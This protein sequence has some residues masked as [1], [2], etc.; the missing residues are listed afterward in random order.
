MNLSTPVTLS[1]AHTLTLS[2]THTNTLD[3][4]SQMN[5]W[6]NNIA[7]VR[8]K[9]LVCAFRLWSLLSA[10]P[11]ALCSNAKAQWDT[12]C[13]YRELITVQGVYPVGYEHA[14][15]RT[16]IHTNYLLHT[17]TNTQHFC[18][19][20][21]GGPSLY[22]PVCRHSSVTSLTAQNSMITP[23]PEERI[24]ISCAIS[25]ALFTVHKVCAAVVFLLK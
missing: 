16:H 18:Y 17:N 24:Q 25:L 2:L 10:P 19:V 21:P 12:G 9:Y 3:V 22:V 14:H 1:H 20:M 4:K 11:R 23:D 8:G 13:S 7:F 15:T 6:H 5:H